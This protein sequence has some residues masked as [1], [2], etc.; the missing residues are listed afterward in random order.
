[1]TE[2]RKERKTE[3]K[4]D[5]GEVYTTGLKKGIESPL[6]NISIGCLSLNRVN[7]SLKLDKNDYWE[8]LRDTCWH[9]QAF[10]IKGQTGDIARP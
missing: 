1:M 7:S 5:N 10:R 4:R 9:T 8:I 6:R 3:R 2:R